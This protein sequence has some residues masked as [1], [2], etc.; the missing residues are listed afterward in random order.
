MQI[1]QEVQIAD[2]T[3]ANFGIVGNEHLRQDL[4]GVMSWELGIGPRE[5]DTVYVRSHEYGVSE[6][7]DNFDP[8]TMKISFLYFG[9]RER[10]SVEDTS[11]GLVISSL[12]TGQSM[13][14]TGVTKADLIPGLIE[15]H[16][17]Q[18]VED[19]LEIPFGYSAE[20]V[21]L[22][23]RAGLLTPDAPAGAGTDWFQTRLGDMT[24]VPDGQPDPGDGGGNP[25]TGG[26]PDPGGGPDMGGGLQGY[27]TLLFDD[28]TADTVEISWNW[29]KKTAITGFD[30]NDDV[31][32]LNALGSGQV[33]AREADGNLYFEVLG[34]GGNSTALVGIQAEDLSMSNLTAP[35]WNTVLSSDSELIV[36]LTGLGFDMM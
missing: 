15:F 35:G 25:D 24:G 11:A 23:S 3:M 36:Q 4:G 13:T 21:T 5:A 8:G 17:D 2:L 18:V 31:I 29:A 12:P 32:D 33:T 16:H 7:I 14:L 26:N 10:L 28:A 1:V 27:E 9:T 20:Q 30:V 6:V 22:V 34:N 19:N